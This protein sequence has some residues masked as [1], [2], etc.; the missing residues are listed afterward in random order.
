MVLAYIIILLLSTVLTAWASLRVAHRLGALFNKPD[1][2]P[3][4][5]F[6]VVSSIA[7]LT[8]VGAPAKLL[9]GAVLLV[10]VGLAYH[11]SFLPNIARWG[12]PFIAVMLGLSTITLPVVGHI[13]PV[14]LLAAAMLVWFGLTLG[15][16]Y[17]PDDA[18][19][20]SIALIIALIP[21]MASPFVFHAPSHIALDAGLISAGLLG[22]L[23]AYRSNDL[24]G[25][26]RAPLT[27]LLG[28]LLL[29]A[30]S[31]GAWVASIVSL[32]AWCGAIA[33]ATQQN[34]PT[35]PDAFRI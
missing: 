18:K 17:T 31:H 12:V 27:L 11:Q 14:A 24:L 4:G 8:V 16:E 7:F 30:A 3:A 28:W 21:L 6:A 20:G 19:A 2:V 35:G 22:L 1:F 34:Q 9:V 5:L 23:A 29:E 10:G 33:Y 26:A 25:V 15:A 32:L 13:P